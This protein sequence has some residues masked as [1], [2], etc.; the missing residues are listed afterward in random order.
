MSSA[1]DVCPEFFRRFSACPTVPLSEFLS[2]PLELLVSLEMALVSSNQ[3]WDFL[4]ILFIAG[5]FRNRINFTISYLVPTLLTSQVFKPFFRDPR[6]VLS[7]IY[8]YGMPSGHST[9]AGAIFSAVIVMYA[10]GRIR[11]GWFALFYCLLMINVGY[12]R[13]YLHYHTK[14]QVLYGFTWGMV[15]AFFILAAFP[16]TSEVKKKQRYETVIF[17][18]LL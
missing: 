8:G 2:R 5:S 6:P 13:I 12:S 17:E 16:I 18:K 1:C 4:L 11:N 14:A 10:R 9:A 15:T 3:A 7:C